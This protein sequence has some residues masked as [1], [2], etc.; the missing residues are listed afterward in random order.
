MN[1]LIIV[2]IF[3]THA[4]N[5]FLNPSCSECDNMFTKI[6]IW[7]S[8]WRRTKVRNLTNALDVTPCFSL[9]VH[10]EYTL[11]HT[12]EK[13]S[14]YLLWMCLSC[15]TKVL[16]ERT[17]KPEEKYLNAIDVNKFLTRVIL[18]KN[19]WTCTQYICLNCDDC[20]K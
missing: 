5:S 18:W 15:L 19:I 4:K 8:T 7:K 17:H 1:Q 13:N 11:S 16:W 2:R 20:G 9:T 14:C 10:Q 6:V 3:K 12:V